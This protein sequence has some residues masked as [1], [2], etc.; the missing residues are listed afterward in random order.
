MSLNRSFSHCLEWYKLSLYNLNRII[1]GFD[2]IAYYILNY[3]FYVAIS[4]VYIVYCILFIVYCILYL[5]LVLCCENSRYPRQ[6]SF[7]MLFNCLLWSIKQWLKKKS[8][9][10]M[11]LLSF[12]K[13]ERFN[14]TLIFSHCHYRFNSYLSYMYS[15]GHFVI[16]AN[17][18]QFAFYIT[19]GMEVY[20][21][22]KL[23]LR[24]SNIMKRLHVRASRASELGKFRTY[25]F[26]NSTVKYWGG[27]NDNT[28]HPPPPHLKY[29]E[30][31][32]P[33]P[34]PPPPPRDRHPW[35]GQRAKRAL[36]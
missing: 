16:S 14:T 23:Y 27:G 1:F 22:H 3:F 28:G 31:I 4:P 30:D 11:S 17:S 15:I 6:S 10:G 5:C 35:W 24:H 36:R 13:L 8:Y 9:F 32:S 33:H 7:V 20:T 25:T 34:S 12:W 26:Q 2:S 19:Y 29:W 21:T 18:M